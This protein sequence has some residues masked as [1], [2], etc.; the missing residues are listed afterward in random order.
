LG[1]LE[2]LGELSKDELEDVLEESDTSELDSNSLMYNL[3]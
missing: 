2:V 3:P 1:L